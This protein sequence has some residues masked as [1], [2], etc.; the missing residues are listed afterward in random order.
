MPTGLSLLTPLHGHLARG[1]CAMGHGELTERTSMA[2]AHGRELGTQMV[3]GTQN[4]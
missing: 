1:V 2:W 3:A 4:G